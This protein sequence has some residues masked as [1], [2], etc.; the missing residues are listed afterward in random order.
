MRLDFSWQHSV[1]QYLSLYEELLQEENEA[2]VKEDAV[3]E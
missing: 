1:Q 3:K 2:P